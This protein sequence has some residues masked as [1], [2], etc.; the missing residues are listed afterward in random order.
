MLRSKLKLAAFLAL[1]LTAAVIDWEADGGAQPAQAAEPQAP[2]DRPAAKAST[3]GADRG[4]E[5]LPVGAVAR[6]GDTRYRHA[7][8]YA[9]SV[10]PDGRWLAILASTGVG[11]WDLNT[12]KVVYRLVGP[13]AARFTPDGKHLLTADGSGPL[14]V[15]EATTGKAVR[16]VTPPERKTVPALRQA[17]SYRGKVT[18]FLEHPPGP[19]VLVGTDAG[20]DRRS[21]C[22][23]LDPAD[24]SMSYRPSYY[25][26]IAYSADGRLQ[27]TCDTS[28]DSLYEYFSVYNAKTNK[29]LFGGHIHS[30]VFAAAFSADDRLVAAGSEE[31]RLWDLKT[32]KEI[33]LKDKTFDVDS[34][35]FSAD[36]KTLLAYAFCNGV[37]GR[38][39]TAVARWDTATGKRLPD[40]RAKA[41]AWTTLVTSDDG[42]L[43][44]TTGLDQVIRRFDLVA[45]T[46]LPSGSGF[47]GPL[48]TALS[49]DGKSVAVGDRAGLLRVWAAPFV[50]LPRQLRAGGAGVTDLAFAPDGRV[51]F[52]AYANGSVGLWDLAAGKERGAL[53]GR[54]GIRALPEGVAPHMAVSA[55]GRTVLGLLPGQSTIWAWDTTTT[56]MT[57]QS[58]LLEEVWGE[59]PAFTPDGAEVLVGLDRG[60]CL[61]LDRA[62]GRQIGKL[63]VPK[64]V[65][66]VRGLAATPDGLWLA[67]STGGTEDGRLSL[68]HR[69]TGQERWHIDFRSKD[70]KSRSQ[71][72]AIALT[73]C[74]TWLLTAHP[75]GRIRAWET[76]T[77]KPAFE[78]VGPAGPISKLQVASDGRQLLADASGAIALLWSLGPTNAGGA[79][80]PVAA[81]LDQLGGEDASAAYRAVWLLADRLD[82]AVDDLRKRLPV[83]RGPDPAVELPRLF[84]DLDSSRFGT[85][86]EATGQLTNLLA[87]HPALWSRV[88]AKAAAPGPLEVQR[89]LED[90]LRTAPTAGA[91]PDEIRQAR[92]LAAVELAGT[93]T[94][95]KLLG[96]WGGGTPACGL[97]TAANAALQR[98]DRRQPRSSPP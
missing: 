1:T 88:Q 94:A 56:R 96:E 90:V 32:G 35:R 31:V 44:V 3:A 36:G 7:R 48:A 76:T 6:F 97:T 23:T 63:T 46:E 92:V 27:V 39:L 34:Y 2:D 86:Q 67:V 8:G 42:K 33:P 91:T 64:A 98:L 59:W 5:P 79:P 43:L 11:V 73:P 40:L 66:R 49:P 68:L 10:S 58:Q 24:W 54:D 4:E 93:A 82:E 13:S 85:R 20:K 28:G 25:D 60:E 29:S 89:R 52:A 95:K 72:C 78:R 53:L 80:R 19:C 45:G 16:T 37:R 21:F 51:L 55:D 26:T 77:G 75:D 83:D 14:R 57:W 65:G 15:W 38:E 9:T 84:A 30:G 18:D 47:T 74:G 69:H 50:S 81:L 70:S 61:R 12:G 22:F 62:T 17:G 41:S 87:R 71:P